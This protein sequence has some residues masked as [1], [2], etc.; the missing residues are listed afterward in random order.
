MVIVLCMHFTNTN[1]L[2]T[3]QTV[4]LLVG[5]S[6]CKFLT[7]SVPT[8]CCW[9][10]CGVGPQQ[11]STNTAVVE[12]C[13]TPTAARRWWPF[14]GH[15]ELS[16]NFTGNFTGKIS[17]SSS[18]L[19][20]PID[21]PPAPSAA[22]PHAMN[23]FHLLVWTAK[24]GGCFVLTDPMA[25]ILCELEAQSSLLLTNNLE[26]KGNGRAKF[27]YVVSSGQ[28]ASPSESGMRPHHLPHLPGQPAEETGEDDD[29]DDN[30]DGNDDDP[31]ACDDAVPLRP[32]SH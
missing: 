8:N 27:E 15:L 18:V 13:S 21:P 26:W 3:I 19:T 22:D 17:S 7:A 6:P 1:G 28:Q 30:S 23:T 20:K 4:K 5:P 32:D 31:N 9:W 24:W 25:F 2:E 11:H 12:P 16:G 10:R 29:D 14:P